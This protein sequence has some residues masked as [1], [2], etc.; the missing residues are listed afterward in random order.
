MHQMVRL[1]TTALP[2]VGAF[3]CLSSLIL[4]LKLHKCKVPSD[5]DIHDPPI[6]FEVSLYITCPCS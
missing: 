2:H 4:R 6:R 3:Q 1:E 5:P